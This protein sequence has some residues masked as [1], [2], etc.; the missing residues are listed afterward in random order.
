MEDSERQL[1]GLYDRVNIS[2]STLNKI[3]I[4]LCVLLIACM[5]FA[6]S[7]RGYQV[8]FDTLG[9]T[10][11]ESQKR[12]YGELLEDPGEP[13]REGYVFDGWYRDP[14]LADPWKLGEDTVTESVTLYAGWKPR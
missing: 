1:R 6:V 10:A 11:V 13:S 12:M 2:V 4:G 5:A 9:G 8:S 7:N 3:I 14:G